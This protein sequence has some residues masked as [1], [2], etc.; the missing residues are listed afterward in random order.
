M[1]KSARSRFDSDCSS[2]NVVVYNLRRAIAALRFA[3]S[4]DARSAS[5]TVAV[6]FAVIVAIV[7]VFR[8]RLSAVCAVFLVSYNYAFAAVAQCP[9][10]H[11]CYAEFA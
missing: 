1:P 11:C 6:W 7:F 9:M 4:A 8:L 3:I 10:T 2:L 5:V